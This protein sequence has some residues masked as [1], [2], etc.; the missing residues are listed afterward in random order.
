MWFHQ[1]SDAPCVCEREAYLISQGE[2]ERPIWFHRER[3]AYL[4]S[5]AVTMLRG[6]DSAIRRSQCHK[7]GYFNRHILIAPTPPP[8][9]LSSRSR[10]SPYPAQTTQRAQDPPNVFED[11]DAALKQTSPTSPPPPPNPHPSKVIII[12]VKYL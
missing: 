8:P 7:D 12:Y 9:S 1:L 3:E 4:V 6:A 5:S 11:T 2:R 10:K